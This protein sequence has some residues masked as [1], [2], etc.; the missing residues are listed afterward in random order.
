MSLNQSEYLQID[1]GTAAAFSFF[2]HINFNISQVSSVLPFEVEIVCGVVSK[3]NFAYA[4][5]E[6][7][8]YQGEPAQHVTF[9]ANSDVSNCPIVKQNIEVRDLFDNILGSNLV[10]LID[11]YESDSIIEIIDKNSPT[12][13]FLFV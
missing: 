5:V 10:K 11:A 1:T 7:A 13:V 12:K 4:P 8:F 6:V 3:V 2:L 9:T